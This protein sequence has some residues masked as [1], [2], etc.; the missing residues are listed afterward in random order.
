MTIAGQRKKA[1]IQIRSAAEEVGGDNLYAMDRVRARAGLV[2]KVY[3]KTILDMA[4]LGTIEMRS[5]PA[6]DIEPDEAA[7]GIRQGDR[8]FTHFSFT[9]HSTG[10]PVDR[11]QRIEVVLQGIERNVWERFEDEVRRRE[12]RGPLAKIQE[13]IRSY[14]ADSAADRG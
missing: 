12:G 8:V 2:R 13:M 10:E 7:R 1:E 5:V 6:D 14:L 4:R 9:G 11:T 3:D